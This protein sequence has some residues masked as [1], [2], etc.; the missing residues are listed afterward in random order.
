[1]RVVS[2]QTAVT[3]LT[4]ILVFYGWTPA[5]AQ[6]DRARIDINTA[7]QTQL[8]TLH[9]IGPSKAES[10][11]QYRDNNG[12]F[13][14]PTQLLRVPGIGRATLAGLCHQI[15]AGGIAGC[16]EEGTVAAMPLSV[17]MPA[18][19]DDGR[20][21]INLAL[22]TEL[23]I[24][25]RIGPALAERIIAHRELHGPFQTVDGLDDVRGIGPATLDGLRDFV[26]VQT[27]INLVSIEMLVA[28]GVPET[29]S[30]TAF[31][32]ENMSRFVFSSP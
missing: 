19:E 17:A 6:D 14:H 22:A 18:A 26:T 7:S 25:P 28:L 16:D 32:H 10:I 9:G 13:E 21:N 23:Q 15:E 29:T 12:S 30:L 1:M 2:P 27:N 31:R 3:L 24:L 11:I 4:V 20:L 8:E 5:S